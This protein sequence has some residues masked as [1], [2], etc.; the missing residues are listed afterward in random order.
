MLVVTEETEIGEDSVLLILF[1]RR[2]GGIGLLCILNRLHTRGPMMRSTLDGSTP[3]VRLLP[4]RV[5]LISHD[6]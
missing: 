4:Y 2:G 1:S 6:R 5:P 3:G